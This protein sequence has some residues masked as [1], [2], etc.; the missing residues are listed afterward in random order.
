MYFYRVGE[1]CRF[2][3]YK[4]SICWAIPWELPC[5]VIRWT[6]TEQVVSYLWDFYLWPC[7]GDEM[8]VPL[9][10]ADKP[11][12]S[13]GINWPSVLFKVTLHAEALFGS[14]AF[15]QRNFSLMQVKDFP[16]SLQIHVS[17]WPRHCTFEFA[18]LKQLLQ[19][20]KTITN[21]QHWKRV[22]PNILKCLF[23]GP[24]NCWEQSSHT[25]W[26]GPTYSLAE[27]GGSPRLNTGRSVSITL[28]TKITFPN[29]GRQV[30]WRYECN[31][32]VSLALGVL[33]RYPR[34]KIRQTSRSGNAVRPLHTPVSHWQWSPTS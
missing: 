17:S 11:L 16:F 8:V 4:A 19:R 31:G 15:Q 21:E 26:T 20:S 1:H 22:N 34:D 32:Q 5:S 27:G 29:C 14:P 13:V 24:I 25:F 18:Y 7:S 23:G 12:L 9:T 33:M 30:A 28:T 6:K 3:S 2:I 10:Y